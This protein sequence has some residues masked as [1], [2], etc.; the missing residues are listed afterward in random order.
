M[1]AE[2]D[3]IPCLE[4]YRNCRVH[5][6]QSPERIS[7]IVKPEI[8]RVF[9]ISDPRELFEICKSV[10]WSPEA[11]LLC[12][13]RLLAGW[14]LATEGRMPRP[15]GVTIEKVKAH[16]AGL[17]SVGWRDHE[18]FCTSLDRPKFHVPRQHRAGLDQPMK[19]DVPLR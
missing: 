14:E 16:T 4:V 5:D 11:R 2:N 19:R 12:R 3:R 15:E 9:A 1:T 7:G 13:A 17:D 10:K 18:Y 6:Q 8:D